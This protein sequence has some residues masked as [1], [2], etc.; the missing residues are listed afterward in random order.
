MLCMFYGFPLSSPLC[1]FNIK[2]QGSS[3]EEFVSPENNYIPSGELGVE[4]Q[5]FRT[6]GF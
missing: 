1:A 5:N 6:V 2:S 4:R 3:C